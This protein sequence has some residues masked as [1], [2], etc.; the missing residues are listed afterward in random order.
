[1]IQDKKYDSEAYKKIYE[2]YKKGKVSQAKE[3]IIEYI[4]MYPAD[5]SSK[6]LLSKIMI[7]LK[8]YEEAEKFLLY[9]INKYPEH[10]IFRQNMVYLYTEL[11]EYEK[12]YKVYKTIDFK[13]YKK[14]NKKSAKELTTLH[15]LLCV[16]QNIKTS[17]RPGYLVNQYK[18]YNEEEALKHICNNHLKNTKL[19]SDYVFNRNEEEIREI[20]KKISIR[21]EEDARK[22]QKLDVVDYYNFK[23]EAIGTSK[24]GYTNVLKVV[25]IKNTNKIITMYPVNKNNAAIINSLEKEHEYTSGKVLKRTSQIDKFKQ[26]YKV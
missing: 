12:A 19:K 4:E 25:T 7:G 21:I 8:E 23:C 24:N 5:I 3:F 17:E 2:L 11:E 16:K 15:A 1:M 20:M 14:I 10:I 6:I 22:E 9:C 18:D 13:E 26:K